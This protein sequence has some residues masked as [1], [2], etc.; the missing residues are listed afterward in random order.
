M[1]RAPDM[2]VSPWIPDE[3]EAV[4]RC[5]HCHHQCVDALHTDRSENHFVWCTWL[6][7]DLASRDTLANS[8]LTLV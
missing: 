8:S 5:R 7:E 6:K 1:S 2:T 3:Y 4:T